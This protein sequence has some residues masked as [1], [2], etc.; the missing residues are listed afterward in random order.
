MK[1]LML[2]T[3]LTTLMSLSI[4]TAHADTWQIDADSS[5]LNFVSVKNETVAE[6]HR[7]TE[8]SGAVTDGNLEVSIPVAS[9]D[10]QIPIRNERMLKHI[11]ASEEYST[12]TVT[13]ELDMSSVDAIPAG[14]TLPLTVDLDVFLAG[15]TGTVEANLQVT[16][17]D[18]D[19][20]LVTTTSPVLISANAFKFS[21]G[22]EQLRTIAGLK[23]IDLVIPVTF[24]VQLALD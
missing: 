5:V 1:T 17:L 18:A 4:A 8:L 16:R 24:S 21:E 7:F 12:I 11:F 23:S 15:T 2:T 9:I 10:T 19:E 13:S 6:T 22:V 20:L 14:S 3:A